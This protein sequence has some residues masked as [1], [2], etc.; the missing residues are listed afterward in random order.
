[1]KHSDYESQRDTLLLPCQNCKKDVRPIETPGV[2]PH[3]LGLRCP[4]CNSSL[5]WVGKP[6]ND[7]IRGKASKYTLTSLGI[8]NCE[9]CGRPDV[10]LRRVG[11]W[12]EIHHK[13]PISEGG[14]DTKEN[15]LIVC[16]RCHSD[17]HHKRTYDFHHLKDIMD[18]ILGKE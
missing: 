5:T 10:W 7:G 8:W 6:K 15:T 4:Q 16:Y 11:E 13:I 9:L 1:M 3:H 12:L 2:G 18:S 17:I 14:L